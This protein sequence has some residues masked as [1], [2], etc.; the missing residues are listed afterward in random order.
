MLAYIHVIIEFMLQ[1]E[2]GDL[3][4]M[5]GIVNEACLAGIRCDVLTSL[6]IALPLLASRCCSTDTTT[7]LPRMIRGITDGLPPGSDRVIFDTHPYFV[8]DGSPNNSP[9][10]TSMDPR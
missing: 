2:Y 9:I 1:P 8:F 5:F 10:M 7:Q 4:P 3:I 6:Y